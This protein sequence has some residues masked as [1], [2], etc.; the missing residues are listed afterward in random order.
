M[1]DKLV[2]PSESLDLLLKSDTC[3]E[4]EKLLFQKYIHSLFVFATLALT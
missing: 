4:G 3:E 1:L 2:F